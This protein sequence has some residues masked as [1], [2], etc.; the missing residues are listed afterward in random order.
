MSAQAA[1]VAPGDVPVFD[2]SWFADV[3]VDYSP[4]IDPGPNPGAAFTDPNQ[5]L[6]RPDVDFASGLQCNAVPTP[7]NCRF[8][9]VG[10][11]GS[12]TVQFTDNVVDGDGTSA[13]DLFIWEVGVAEGS[14]VEISADGS[15]WT[16]VGTIEADD[17]LGLGV[18]TYGFDVDAAGFGIGD[19]FTFVRLTDL[20]L[21]DTSSPRGSDFDAIGGVTTV[22]VPAAVWL[23]GSALVGLG[24]LRRRR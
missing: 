17:T 8:T 1:L 3:V 4:V 24:W 20:N 9:S 7:E 14:T 11:G 15:A 16:T 2:D 12:L 13:F 6:G 22:P 23:F 18:F 19:V 5:A 21:M 10:D